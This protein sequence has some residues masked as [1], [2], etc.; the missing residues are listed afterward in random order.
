[1][2]ATKQL[3]YPQS[4]GTLSYADL[5]GWNTFGQAGG[6]SASMEEVA[7]GDVGS[8]VAS[9]SGAVT[10][11]WVAMVA[12]LIAIRVLYQLGK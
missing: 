4:P 5:Y 11:S 1:M 10:I 2:G 8:T 7:S 6:V 12:L 3:G 9:G